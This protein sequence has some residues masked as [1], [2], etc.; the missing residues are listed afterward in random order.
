M[1]KKCR[2][3]NPF[4]RRRARLGEWG[5][6][7]VSKVMFNRVPV[8]WRLRTF[9]NGIRWQSPSGTRTRSHGVGWHIILH[10]SVHMENLCVHERWTVRR[11]AHS[12]DIKFEGDYN[13]KCVVFGFFGRCSCVVTVVIQSF[14]ISVHCVNDDDDDDGDS[15][16]TGGANQKEPL[17][18]H[19]TKS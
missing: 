9:L 4:S 10:T 13:R 5:W 7:S 12:H 6:I 19:N 15:R 17:W 3:E 8:H 1:N 14:R 18:I 2:K 11:L 16:R